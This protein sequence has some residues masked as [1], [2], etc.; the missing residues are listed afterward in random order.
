VIPG[1]LR[2]LPSFGEK[3]VWLLTSTGG[4]AVVLVSVGVVVFAY[5]DLR[6]EV[7]DSIESRSRVAAMNSGAPLAFD[8]RAN[9]QEALAALNGSPHVA[10]ATVFD[11]EGRRFAQF[12]RDKDAAPELPL[13]DRLGFV[14]RGEWQVY[15]RPVE[16]AGRPLG[17][18]Q[19]VFDLRRL[20]NRVATLLGV[21]VVIAL[22]AVLLLHVVSRGLA[23]VLVQPVDELSRT[24]RLISQT[25]NFGLRV[26]PSSSDEIG[27]LTVDFNDMLDELQ[28]QHAELQ[29]ARRTAEEASRSKDEFLA[30]LSHEL[31]TPMTP[32]LGWSQI[33]LRAAHE[34]ERVRQGAEIVER[35]ARIQTRIIDDLLDMSRIIAGKMVLRVEDVDLAQ[36]VEQALIT[37]HAAAEARGVALEVALGREVPKVR[38]DPNRL[39]QIAWNLLSNAI[40]FTPRGG[41]VRISLQQPEAGTVRLAVSDDGQGMPPELIPHVFERFR[42]ADSSTTRAQG[43]LGL[44]LA[45]VKQ[46]AEQHGGSVSASSGGPGLGSTFSIDLPVPLGPSLSPRPDAG[47]S[48]DPVGDAGPKLLGLRVLLVDDEEDARQLMTHILEEAGARVLGADS[49]A[50][51]L[52]QLRSAPVDVLVSDIGMPEADGYSLVRAIRNLPAEQGG[53]LPAIALTAFAREEDRQ[54]ALQAG[55]DLHLGKPVEPQH[56]VDSVDSIYRA[57]RSR[58]AS[59]G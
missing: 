11:H 50:Q 57:S 36:V 55:F 19:V 41:R 28:K 46:L 52:M 24:A 2:R 58:R 48:A 30:T 31:R 15:T 13:D 44:G 14:E 56:L 5:F 53:L 43:G 47:E 22:G 10:R 3:V 25:R 39:Q 49:A 38:G 4:L 9:A 26:T 45:I 33:L 27:Q 7:F 35:N 51:A 12:A 6:N 1:W 8:D 16:D 23:R 29:A 20:R 42:Q 34:P 32:I 54:R 18:V 37:V 59:G 21:V 17:F 40:K